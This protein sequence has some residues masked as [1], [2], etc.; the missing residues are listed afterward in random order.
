MQTVALALALALVL[1]HLLLLTNVDGAFLR[2]TSQL[3]KEGNIPQQLKQRSFICL[4]ANTSC[5]VPV[6]GATLAS[7]GSVP[8]PIHIGPLQLGGHSYHSMLIFLNR[9]TDLNISNISNL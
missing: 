1:P 2:E 5:A 8:E 6:N 9:E 7:K 4:W 3:L